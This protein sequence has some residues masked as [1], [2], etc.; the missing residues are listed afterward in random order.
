MRKFP[1]YSPKLIAK[2][3]RIFVE[4][5]IWVKDLGV[6]HFKRG[7]LISTKDSL[8][9]VKNAVIEMNLLNAQ[10]EGA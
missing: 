4:G 8:P 9:E 3:V 1:V 10:K 7:Q 6:I 5:A 2:H